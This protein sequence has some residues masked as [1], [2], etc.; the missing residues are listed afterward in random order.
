MVI[1]TNRDYQY[2]AAARLHTALCTVANGGIKEGL[3][4]ATEIIDAVPPGHRTNVVTHTA[5]LVL[6]AVPPEQR[7]SPAA[8]DLRAVLGEP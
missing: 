7:I 3:T 4:A 8:A 1:A 2:R 5:R 6:N